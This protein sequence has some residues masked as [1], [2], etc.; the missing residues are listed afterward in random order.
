[1]DPNVV[2][3]FASSALSLVFAAVLA[4]QWRARR[5]PYQLIWAVGMLW[6]GLSAGTEFLGGALGWSEPL[7][8]AWY[9][10]G[11]IWVAG[12][13]GLGTVYLLARTRFGYAFAVCLGLAGLF[14]FLTWKKYDY[15][16]SGVAPFAYLGIAALLAVAV[17]VLTW[18]RDDR[19]VHLA[20]GVVVGGSL[21]SLVMAWVLIQNGVNG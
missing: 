7:Y 5:R 4:T 2:L 1:M 19:W 9:L 18:R 14:T 6:Y 21:V 12:W 3:P 15:P 13:L 20:G 16:N 17:V 8:R 11:A 10:I